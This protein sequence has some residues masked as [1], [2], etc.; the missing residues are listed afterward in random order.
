MK[1]LVCF[2]TYIRENVVY[3]WVMYADLKCFYAS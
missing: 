2:T 3:A 1:T